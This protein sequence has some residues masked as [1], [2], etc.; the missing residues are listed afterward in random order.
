MSR[1][2]LILLARCAAAL[3]LLIVIRSLGEVFRL[4]YGRADLPGY[5]EIRPFI[6]GALAAALALAVTLL[7]IVLDRPRTGL[8]LAGL[9][10][11]ALFFYRV[12]FIV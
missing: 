1:F 8:V 4:E 7:A 10:V 6:I 5:G 12:Y 9:T 3:L 2:S 11:V